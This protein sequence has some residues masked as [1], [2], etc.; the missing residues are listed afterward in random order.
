MC[1]V[2]H[3][4]CLFVDNFSG[5]T[6]DYEPTNMQL[7][8][9]KPNLTPF[10]QPCDTGI[11]CCLK[12]LYRYEFCHRAVELDDTGEHNIYKINLL[13]GMMMAQRAWNQVS[14]QMI[15][16]CWSHTEIQL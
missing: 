7:E 2:N 14:L 9:F 10:V 11:I 4:V 1:V 15:A 13:E 8:F 6:V 12:A 3:R 16:N 5:H